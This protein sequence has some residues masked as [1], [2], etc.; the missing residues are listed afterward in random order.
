MLWAAAGSDLI[1]THFLLSIEGVT[2]TLQGL[3]IVGPIVA[4]VVTKRIC[5]ALQK[6]DREI[7][8]HGF[9][10]GRIVRLPGG[11]FIEVH[12]QVDEYERWKLVSFD[13]YT[14]LMLRPDE[15]GRIT[16][17]MRLR[18]GLS[19]WFFQDRI[20]PVSR[21]ELEERSAGGGH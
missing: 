15:R 2:H 14:P 7:V 13:E 20:A 9:E 4:Y 11:E 17:R 12:D 8:L 18:A 16:A 6:K 3:L 10:S 5:I 19:R 21:G 1:A